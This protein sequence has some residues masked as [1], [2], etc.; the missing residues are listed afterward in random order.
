MNN[1]GKAFSFVFDD[2]AW[3]RKTAVAAIY[4]FLSIVGIGIPI[5]AGYFVRIT[6]AVMRNEEPAL[7]DW[8]S[9]GR[10]FVTG[11]KLCVAYLVYLLPVALLVLPVL[12]LALLGSVAI[13]P[14]TILMIMTVYLFG[15]TVLLIP[16]SLAVSLFSPIIVLLFARREKIGD[17]VDLVR[18]VR[19]FRARWQDALVIALI[20]LGIQSLSFLGIAFFVVGVFFTIFYTY[21]V[22]SYLSGLL[23][24]ELKAAGEIE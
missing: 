22:S 24:L 1:L 11:L 5:L 4:I 7:P 19:L 15:F 14:D 12:A 18:V 10:M 9:T 8:R 2:P 16:Y 6:Q 13:E 23:Y 20:A 17:A 21:S 3:L